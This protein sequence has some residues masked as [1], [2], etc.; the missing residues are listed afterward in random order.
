MTSFSAGDIVWVPFPHVESDEIKSRP[1][2][3]ISNAPIGPEGGLFWAMM[4]TNALRP[5]WPGDIIVEDLKAAGLPHPSKIRTGKIA[6]LEVEGAEA[7]G[8]I[9]DA[10]LAEVRKQMTYYLEGTHS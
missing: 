3:V 2:L 8:R 9:D 6:T 5:G 4:V 1:A 10:L 7:I